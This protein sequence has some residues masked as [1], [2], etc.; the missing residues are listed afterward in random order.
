MLDHVASNDLMAQFA[1]DRGDLD[2]ADAVKTE[3]VNGGML[4]DPFGGAR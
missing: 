1:K 3:L 4:L 2:R